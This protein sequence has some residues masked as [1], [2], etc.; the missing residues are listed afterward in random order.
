MVRVKA[1]VSGQAFRRLDTNLLGCLERSGGVKHRNRLKHN[2]YFTPE[3][4]IRKALGAISHVE[5]RT[6]VDPAAGDGKFIR[7]AS[8]LWPTAN[9]F[10]VDV[11]NEVTSRARQSVNSKGD[12]FTRDSLQRETW[13]KIRKIRAILEEGGFDLVVGNPPFS[14]WFDRVSDPEVLSN[15]T[16]AHREGVLR[17]S[18]S[19]EILFIEISIA[20]ARQGGFIVI[21]LPDGVLSNPQHEYVRRYVLGQTRVKKVISL[22]RNVFQSTSAKTSILILEKR[23]PQTEDYYAEISDLNSYGVANT[24]VKVCQTDLI[25]RMDYCY[26]QALVSNELNRLQSKSLPLVALRSFATCCKTGKTLYGK[27][28]VFSDKGLRFLHATNVTDIGINYERDK[29]FVAPFSEMHFPDAHA[30]VGDIVFVRVGVG[31]AGRVGII[32]AQ[33]DEG[34]ATD[35]IHL[36]TVKDIDPH[37]LVVYLKTRFGKDTINLLKHGVG[38]VSINK[39]DLLSLPIPLIPAEVQ[40]EVGAKYRDILAS[41]RKNR[42]DNGAKEMMTSLIRYLEDRLMSL[43]G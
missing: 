17:K 9:L 32:D 29:R 35:Y 21:V 20:L 41:Y 40:A 14:S 11:D 2:Q 34:V 30:Q 16:L 26:Y 28:R 27:R 25:R 12:F 5:V 24:S 18:Q 38:T 23:H 19:I 10:G 37:F 6:V 22:P 7:V 15:Y 33:E 3:F 36:L 1:K 8:D 4:V 13:S 31:C 42:Q 43:T 39:A